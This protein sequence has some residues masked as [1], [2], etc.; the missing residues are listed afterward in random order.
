MTC[1]MANETFIWEEK[2][3]QRPLYYTSKALEDPEIK[4]LKVIL[5]LV[6]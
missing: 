3:V 6:H 4:N 5:L 1:I 2:K